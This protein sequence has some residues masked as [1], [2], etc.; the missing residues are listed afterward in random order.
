MY[1]VKISQ[2]CSISRQKIISSKVRSSGANPKTQ[3][4]LLFP[5]AA[6]SHLYDIERVNIHNTPFLTY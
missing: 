5:Q 2:R 4:E 6:I 3:T 1:E